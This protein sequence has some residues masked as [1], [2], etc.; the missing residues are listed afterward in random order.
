MD[1]P[2]DQLI[3]AQSFNEMSASTDWFLQLSLTITV[4]MTELKY[5]L[6]TSTIDLQELERAEDC[7]ALN[8]I[9][10]Q[11]EQIHQWSIE[12]IN[13][14]L[15]GL[16]W[17]HCS[18]SLF[19]DQIVVVLNVVRSTLHLNVISDFHQFLQ[20]H[21]EICVQALIQTVCNE[22]QQTLQHAKSAKMDML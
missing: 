9:C 17:A 7:T 10:W 3:V 16:I 21:H 5:Q 6:I 8:E 13:W 15:Q 11:A 2:N 14:K 18:K 20:V 22:I 1:A 4:L 12:D 19:S